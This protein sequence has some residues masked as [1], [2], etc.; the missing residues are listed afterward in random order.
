MTIDCYDDLLKRT[1]ASNGCLEWQGARNPYGFVHFK[2]I[3][4]LTHRVTWELHN[5]PIPK[6]LVIRHECHNPPCVNI[7]HLKLG[8]YKENTQDGIKANRITP[9]GE[10]NAGAKLTE[11]EMLFIYRRLKG[12]IPQRRIAEI[13]GVSREA[14]SAIMTRRNW[15]FV[16]I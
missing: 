9:R 14:V 11:K 13:F 4:K 3:M 8:T 7:E 1:K 16:E 15:R 12:L 10:S 2:G 6:G 5:G